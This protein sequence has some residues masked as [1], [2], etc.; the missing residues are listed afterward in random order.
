VGPGV[1]R[2]AVI[3]QAPDEPGVIPGDRYVYRCETAPVGKIG[4][5]AC[6][7][8]QFGNSEFAVAD[9]IDDGR[10]VID[11]VSHVNFSAMAYQNLRGFYVVVGGS[12][13]KRRDVLA[14]DIWIR[15]RFEKDL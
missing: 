3:E 4:I 1:D 12:H 7:E 11:G 6:F 8:E 15:T 2:G 9:S 13:M 5:R 10:V 14:M